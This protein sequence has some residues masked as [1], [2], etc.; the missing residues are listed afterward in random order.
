LEPQAGR[1][2]HALELVGDDRALGA[3]HPV[4]RGGVAEELLLR[5]QRALEGPVDLAVKEL[6]DLVAEPP[7]IPAAPLARPARDHDRVAEWFDGSLGGPRRHGGSA[8]QRTQAGDAPATDFTARD[9]SGSRCPFARCT[10]LGSDIGGRLDGDATGSFRLTPE[11]AFGLA[12]ADQFHLAACT[13]RGLDR[14]PVVPPVRI[15]PAAGAD[16]GRKITTSR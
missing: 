12:P 8:C 2:G 14:P 9:H 4:A 15:L 3:D 10:P 7:S 6:A 11:P 1:L 5:G 13:P 16:L